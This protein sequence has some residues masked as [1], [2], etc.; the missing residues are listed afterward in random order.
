MP[1]QYRL[2]LLPLNLQI[3]RVPPPKP[4]V[5]INLAV[6]K[7]RL[8]A[9]VVIASRQQ[10]RGCWRNVGDTLPTGAV[11]RAPA[12]RAVSSWRVCMMGCHICLR[13]RGSESVVC[14]C[15]HCNVSTWSAGWV[16]RQVRR[17]RRR[18]R[19]ARAAGGRSHGGRIPRWAC[20]TSPWWF[21]RRGASGVSRILRGAR[22]V[23]RGLLGR[24]GWQRSVAAGA[25][26]RVRLVASWVHVNWLVVC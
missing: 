1:Y 11:R 10:P 12:H 25:V 9:V 23:W 21:M 22:S 20:W 8:R 4:N 24:R 5:W 18:P 3:Q 15:M 6:R 13:R 17:R 19:A 7:A 26:A 2:L 16:A 14:P